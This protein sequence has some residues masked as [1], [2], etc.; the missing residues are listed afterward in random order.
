VDNLKQFNFI[1]K[2]IVHF[3]IEA[4]FNLNNIIKE[5]EFKSACVVIDHALISLPIFIDF[6]N[7]LQCNVK[8]IKCDISEPTYEKLEEKRTKLK[9]QDL[10]DE[11]IKKNNV[12]AHR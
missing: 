2:G 10:I 4:R 11:I 5:N 6:I 8:I 9:N 1:F 3:G 7:K 12:I